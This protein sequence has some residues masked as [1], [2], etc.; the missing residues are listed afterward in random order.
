M[1]LG[2]FV[3][4]GI[5]AALLGLVACAPPSPSGN[6]Q[7]YGELRVLG[8][9]TG[10]ERKAF[11][12]VVAPFEHRSRVSV[13]YTSTRDLTGVLAR[14][15]AAGDPPDLAGLAGPAHMRELSRSG[16]LRDLTDILDV[17]HYRERVAPTFIDL[18]SVDGRLTGVFVRSSVKGLIWYDPDVFQL[19]TP[20]TWDELQRMAVQASKRAS[21]EWCVGL[22]SRESSG[23]PGTDLVE[24]FLLRTA[25]PQTYD[26]WVSGELPWTAP[27]IR[28][29]FQ[30]FLQVVA[31]DAVFG[32]T[33][34][35]MSTDF[36]A[37]GDPL[38]ADPPGCL[39]LHQG[40]FMPV[41]L[42]ADG[43]EPGTD[44]D[45]LP[46]PQLS[47]SERAVI[48]AGD[49]F[50]LLTDDP[51][52]AELI[53]YLVSDEAQSIWIAKSGSLSV[54][55]TIA[56]YPDPVSRQAARLLSGAELF[57]FD[58]SDLMPAAMA[59]AFNA[60]ILTVTDDPHALDGVLEDLDSVR[61]TAYGP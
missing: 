35:A 21:A 17:G 32:G 22:S 24:Q 16:A 25:G 29:A 41:F 18:G 9:W 47:R 54:D 33:D 42:E 12:A 26:A 27:E 46:F 38:F 39:F 56:N 10:Q 7:A 51:S 4:I 13:E 20:T 1:P 30:L 37:A 61:A 11:E 58:A 60:A 45:F 3:A 15:L 31:E 50:G 6:K 36:A 49:L 40:S 55:A 52:A 43:R 23:W 59:D 34:A 28:L 19:G 14:E 2:R 8:S 5:I 48:G 57:R 44:F 53:R